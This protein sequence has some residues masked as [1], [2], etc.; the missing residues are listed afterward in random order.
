MAT[1]DSHA[2]NHQYYKLYNL[3]TLINLLIVSKQSSKKKL[4]KM[5]KWGS[6]VSAGALPLSGIHTLGTRHVTN[7]RPLAVLSW[8]IIKSVI[9]IKQWQYCTSYRMIYFLYE[10]NCCFLSILLHKYLI[11]CFF[12]SFSREITIQKYFSYLVSFSS[13]MNWFLTIPI[14]FSLYSDSCMPKANGNVTSKRKSTS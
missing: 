4:I 7:N 1:G 10:V 12:T 13:Q 3:G 2:T 9:Y 6:P 5:S 8:Q 11:L 14:I